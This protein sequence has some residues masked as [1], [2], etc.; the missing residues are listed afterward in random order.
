[1]EI[2]PNKIS[3]E[4]IDLKASF[5]WPV[6]MVRYGIQIDPSM[7]YFRSREGL[8]QEEE[9]KRRIETSKKKIE[10]AR[11]FLW[12]WERIPWVKMVLIT[13]SVA[14]MNALP[15][16]DID[17]WVICDPRRIWLTRLFDWVLL[18]LSGVRRRR[19]T[20]K[21]RDTFCVNFYK[22]TDNLSL[23][24]HNASYA[25]QVADAIVIMQEPGLYKKLLRSNSWLKEYLPAWYEKT[26][27]ENERVPDY[28]G[29]PQDFIA[30]W[31]NNI[32]YLVGSIQIMIRDRKFVWPRPS[33]V[34]SNEMNTWGDSEA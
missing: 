20:K 12:V 30:K 13:G 9:L 24:V 7:E 11:K 3:K 10:H 8:L 5:L 34:F 6:D 15:E 28:E 18:S 25:I 22:T 1:M 16:H 14:S 17:F 26:M 32:E 27:S 19:G 21:L 2:S 29:N 23:W 33:D 31:V 4:I